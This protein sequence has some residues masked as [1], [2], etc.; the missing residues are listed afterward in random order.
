LAEAVEDALFYDPRVSSFDIRAEVSDGT[1]TL[2]GV[3]DNLAA[4]R[5]AAQDA[6]H[7]VGVSYVKNRIKVRPSKKSNDQEIKERVGRALRRHPYVAQKEIKVRVSNGIVR[8]YGTVDSNFEKAQAESVS[9]RVKG[10]VAVENK[11][12]A[13][14]DYE[15]LA[16]EPYVDDWYP[17]DEDRSYDWYSPS[18]AKKPDK[19][20]RENIEKE[21]EWSPF[22]DAGDIQVSVEDGG[23]TLR[24]T[25]QSW[26][27]YYAA[28][29]NAFE[30]GAVWVYNKLEVRPE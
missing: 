9:S 21:R 20:I 3:V 17:Y 28:R 2:R 19:K 6:R 16:Y 5:A 7:T 8:L 11:L 1:A 26:G 22:V 15:P 10:V 27:E 25:V 14:R 12:A 13:L 4:K 24:G 18:F 30:G 29:E 23:A